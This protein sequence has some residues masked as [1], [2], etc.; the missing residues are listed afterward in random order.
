MKNGVKDEL[1][2]LLS[3]YGPFFILLSM[4]IILSII[5]PYFFT[6]LNLTTILIQT[7]VVAI[8][9]IGQTLV[10]IT[11]GIDLSVGS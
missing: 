6:V 3:K 11:G 4:L 5:S 7:A 8:I 10:I 9:A 1:R 2:V